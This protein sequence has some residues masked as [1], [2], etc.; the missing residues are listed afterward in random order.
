MTRSDLMRSLSTEQLLAALNRY[1]MPIPSLKF[2]DL[3]ILLT[4][5]EWRANVT[6]HCATVTIFNGL[7]SWEGQSDCL[8]KA[9]AVALVN[10][11][12]VG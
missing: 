10:M 3:E 6:L 8:E 2:C 9:L 5:L 1:V 12:A 11:R 7:Q 4:G